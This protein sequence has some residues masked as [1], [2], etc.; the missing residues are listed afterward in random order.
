M[1]GRIAVLIAIEILSIVDEIRNRDVS[2]LI[3]VI[4]RLCRESK[5]SDVALR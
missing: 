2:V 3:K 1:K 5:N 4:K